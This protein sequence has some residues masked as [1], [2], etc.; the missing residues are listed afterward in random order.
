MA[1]G[2][3]RTMEEMVRPQFFFFFSYIL[4]TSY[5]AK[6]TPTWACFL[7][8]A[9]IHTSLT[10]SYPATS[11]PTSPLLWTPKM[12]LHGCVFDVRRL[13]SARKP[14]TCPCGHV[15]GFHWLPFPSPHSDNKNASMW[16]RF[17]CLQALLHSKSRNTPMEVCFCFLL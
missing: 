5:R 15:S 17:C 2:P 7:F 16:T 12:C 11:N 1:M 6:N 13:S 8:L 9:A 4:T 3:C 14:E 10:P